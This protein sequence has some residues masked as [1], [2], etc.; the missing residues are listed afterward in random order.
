MHRIEVEVAF[1][2]LDALSKFGEEHTVATD[3]AVL[4]GDGLAHVSDAG[5]QFVELAPMRIK[6]DRD[7]VEPARVLVYGA[8][9]LIQLALERIQSSGVVAYRL[10]DLGQE[11][12]D[13]RQVDPVT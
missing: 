11:V 5:Q 9:D 8:D 2:A 1:D 4:L 6:H 7:L 3:V 13:G 12:V 10:R